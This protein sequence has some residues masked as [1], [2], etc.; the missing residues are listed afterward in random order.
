M[1][2]G[3]SSPPE[4]LESELGVGVVIVRV[5]RRREVVD[6]QY[7]DKYLVLQCVPL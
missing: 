3:I 4:S 2:P 7:V 6:F 1:D 5:H